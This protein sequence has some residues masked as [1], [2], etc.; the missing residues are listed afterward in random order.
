LHKDDDIATDDALCSGHPIL[1]APAELARDSGSMLLGASLLRGSHCGSNR[2]GG[3]DGGRR[4][5]LHKDDD[6]ATDDALCSWH[7]IQHVPAELTRDSGSM[8]LGASLL[9]GSHCGSNRNGGND[10]GG[11]F[12]LHEDDDIATDDAIRS[13]HLIQHAPAELTR[14]SGSMLLGASLLQG[15]HCGSNRNGGN[16]GGGRFALHEDDNIDTDDALC[17]GHLIQH[18]PAELTRDSGSMLLGASLL[19]GSHCGSNQNGGNNGSR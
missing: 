8:L 5:A 16:D 12:A 4:F 7:P 6:I 18:A 9:Q 14:D 10:G 15:S 17:S 3:N 11:R 1:H 13:G 19:Q 2:N